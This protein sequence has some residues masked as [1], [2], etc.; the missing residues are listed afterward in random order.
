MRK[1]FRILLIVLLIAVVLTWTLF[2]M[3]GHNVPGSTHAF[4][5]VII[6]FLGFLLFVFN[7]G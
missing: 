6:L 7:K 1:F 3:S 2:L 4:F 5:I